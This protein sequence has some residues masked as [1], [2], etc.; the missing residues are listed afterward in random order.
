MGQHW[1]SPK[2]AATTVDGYSA[3]LL[4]GIVVCVGL[5]AG[6]VGCVYYIAMMMVGAGR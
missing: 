5:V 1:R 6:S 4:L 2:V 3:T